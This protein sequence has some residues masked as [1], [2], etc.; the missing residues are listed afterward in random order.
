MTDFLQFIIDEKAPAFGVPI[1]NH[2]AEFD[3]TTDLTLNIN[4]L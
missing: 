4:W 3:T 2:W 1:Y